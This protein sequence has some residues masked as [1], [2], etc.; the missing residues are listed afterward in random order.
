[1]K[2]PKCGYLGFETTDRCRNCNY[3]FSL[4]HAPQAARELS[5]RDDRDDVSA[6]ADFELSGH[7]GLSAAPAAASLD[8]HIDADDQSPATRIT[9][10]D[11]LEPRTTPVEAPIAGAP[12]VATA[13]PRP[14]PRA[15]STDEAA[16]FVAAP[17][18]A[19]Q[20]L[21]VRRATPEL[22][23]PRPRSPARASRI[24]EPTLNLEEPVPAIPAISPPSPAAGRGTEE[25]AGVFARIAAAL[26]DITLLAGIDFVVLFLT[27]RVTGLS[28]S[29]EDLAVLK[30]VPLGAFFALMALGYLAAFTAGGGQTIGKMALGV[31]VLSDDGTP[32]D[33]AGAMLR[34]LGALAAVVTLG[35]LYLPVLVTSD[36]RALHD[37]LAGTRVVKD[38]A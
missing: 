24:E 4:A 9:P 37:R 19:G 12:V 30:L 14:G 13:A 8:L 22:A 38:R 7:V 18:P 25:L 17:R 32:V 27:T 26:I 36:R 11:D 34:S 10:T 16:P 15:A 21:S 2:C 20:P 35:M 33:F 1:M 29:A 23:R 6:L 3:D 31:R 5:L 28:M